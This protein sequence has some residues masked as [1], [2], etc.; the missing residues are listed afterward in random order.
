VRYPWEHTFP[1]VVKEHEL[2]GA[3][4]SRARPAGQKVITPGAPLVSSFGIKAFFV[5]V[6]V[7]LLLVGLAFLN[8]TLS[9]PFDSGSN[10]AKANTSME[11]KAEQQQEKAKNNA[12]PNSSAVPSIE[13]PAKNSGVKLAVW[14]RSLAASFANSVQ[15]MPA[16]VWQLIAAGALVVLLAQALFYSSKAG[17]LSEAGEWFGGIV[18]WLAAFPAVIRADFARIIMPAIVLAVVAFIAVGYFFRKWLGA[19]LPGFALVANNLVSFLSMARDFFLV[20][21]IYILVGIFA[22]IAVVGFLMTAERRGNGSKQQ[23]ADLEK[24]LNNSAPVTGKNAGSK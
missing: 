6:I 8:Q 18:G 1:D 11:K 7:I 4:V 17:Q 14:F 5:V 2:P 3:E 19:N 15:E 23:E 9:K 20:Y 16:K 22:L 21:K 24:Q 12:S 13:A 10:V